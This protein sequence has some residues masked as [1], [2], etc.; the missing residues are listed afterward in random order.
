M[1]HFGPDK[2]VDSVLSCAASVLQADGHIF[3]EWPAWSAGWNTVE[4]RDFR[5]QQQCRGRELYLAACDSCGF[6]KRE[7]NC[8]KIADGKLSLLMIAS[9]NTLVS[10]VKGTILIL[11][12]QL[13]QEGRAYPVAMVRRLVNGLRS[14]SPATA[15]SHVLD[16]SRQYPDCF[17]LTHC[18]PLS[19]LRKW[20]NMCFLLTG[21]VFGS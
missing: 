3:W 16:R 19:V 10:N 9:R 17:L 6:A 11:G 2:H 1:Q 4:L 18:L 12:E 13:T 14:G 20:E 8:W 5:D 15:A 21:S 7:T